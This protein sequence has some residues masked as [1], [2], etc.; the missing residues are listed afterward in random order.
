MNFDIFSNEVFSSRQRVDNRIKK[1][2]KRKNKR[3]FIRI[4]CNRIRE[5]HIFGFQKAKK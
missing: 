2:Q 5:F 1:D 4:S 3:K